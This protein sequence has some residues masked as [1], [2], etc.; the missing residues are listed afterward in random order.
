MDGIKSA[1][2]YI[3]KGF[4]I[5]IYIS[6]L[7]VSRLTFRLFHPLWTLPWTLPWTLVLVVDKKSCGFLALPPFFA[8]L[9]VTLEFD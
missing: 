5:F 4:F 9:T 6:Y 7:A 1:N 8:E 3:C 2:A